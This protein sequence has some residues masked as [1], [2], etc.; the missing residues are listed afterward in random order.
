MASVCGFVF[1]KRDFEALMG[2]LS[3]KKEIFKK[4]RKQVFISLTRYDSMEILWIL[5]DRYFIIKLHF[6]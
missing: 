1:G 4:E 3:L 5:Y 2:F 6:I